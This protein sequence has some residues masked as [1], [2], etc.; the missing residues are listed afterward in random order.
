MFLTALFIGLFAGFFLG[1]F[2]VALLSTQ[3]YEEYW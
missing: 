3:K 2:F 1:V